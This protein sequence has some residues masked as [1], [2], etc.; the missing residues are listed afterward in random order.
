MKRIAILTMSFPYG[1]FA[2]SF[3]EDEIS[4]ICR[5][6]DVSIDIYPFSIADERRDL[7]SNIHCYTDLAF[8]V[9][10][11]A[12]ENFLSF[13]FSRL[14]WLIPFQGK[15]RPLS[16][17]EYFQAYKYLFGA[18]SVRN[19]II[20][21]FSVLSKGNEPI[22]FYSYW[23]NHLALGLTLAKSSLKN[24]KFLVIS[25]AHRYDLYERQIGVY[26]PYRNF[27][28]ENI[29]R[30][31]PISMD[32]CNFLKKNYSQFRDK[33]FI[34]RLGVYPLG[35]GDA[36]ENVGDAIKVVSCSR[37][38]NVKRVD[39]ILNSLLE[40]HKRTQ[41]KIHW[42][43]FGDGPLFHKLKH[44]VD[45]VSNDVFCVELKG[46]VPNFVVREYYKNNAIDIFINLSI[47]EGIPVS[48]MECISASIPVI[49]TDVGGNREIVNE[50]T[51]NLIAVN[52]EIDD[53]INAVFSILERGIS[54]KRT[55]YKFFLENY[56]AQTNYSE[57][58][59]DILNLK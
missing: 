18:I 40:F 36:K 17:R 9:R 48:I 4:L 39:L 11:N 16:L 31:F 19:F 34:H 26:F 52:F 37:V 49:A 59:N 6:R 54:L 28:L 55:C 42:V 50:Q 2:E 35:N 14:F 1:R 15:Y 25:R 51:G 8:F 43:H 56:N 38:T 30:V 53:F 58:Y 5:N 27:T 24:D 29:N 47:S 22:V 21:R 13:L 12:L 32:G 57:F 7:P 33:I 20:K 3:L 23:F 10:K 45:S 44:E 41:R 46:A